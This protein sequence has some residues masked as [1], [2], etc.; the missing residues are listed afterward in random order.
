MGV[1]E[2]VWCSR[3]EEM[4]K[5]GGRECCEEVKEVGRK[6]EAFYKR[7]SEWDLPFDMASIVPDHWMVWP[8]NSL[9]KEGL[10]VEQII[11]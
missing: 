11:K 9:A 8:M 5:L 6:V 2:V 1:L 7:R 4:E 3:R 10:W